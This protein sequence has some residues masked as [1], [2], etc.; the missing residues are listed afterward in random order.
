MN[1]TQMYK[2][3]FS[4]YFLNFK[5][6]TLLIPRFLIRNHLKGIFEYNPNRSAGLFAGQKVARSVIYQN[7][8]ESMINRFILNFIRNLSNYY[9]P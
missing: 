8:L 4:K 7:V 1:S 2:M 9:T 3:S 5:V 6:S